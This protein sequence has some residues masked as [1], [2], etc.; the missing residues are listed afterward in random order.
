MANK[1]QWFIRPELGWPLKGP[2][3]SRKELLEHLDSVKGGDIR[4]EK[5]GPGC[6]EVHPH[7]LFAM[8]GDLVDDDAD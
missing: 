6:Y 4:L 2:F 1:K 7:N 8:R 3:N 5:W